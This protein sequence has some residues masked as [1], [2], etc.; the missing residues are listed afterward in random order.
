[1]KKKI[2]LITDLVDQRLRKEQEIEYY[3]KELQKI[4]ERLSYLYKE[5]RQ[6]KPYLQIIQTESHRYQRV[7]ASEVGEQIMKCPKCDTEMI[8]N[9]DFDVQELTQEQ[10]DL[11]SCHECPECKGWVEVYTIEEMV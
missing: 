6:P 10:Y 7:Y 9:N 5:K 4:Q 11:L 1:M 8:W 3:E 2:I